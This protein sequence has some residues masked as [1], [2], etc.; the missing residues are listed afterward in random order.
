MAALVTGALAGVAIRAGAK[1]V[2]TLLRAKGGAAGGVAAEMVDK[3]AGELG[4]EAD[5]GA[6]VE[7]HRA[8]PDKVEAAIRDVE[9]AN[10][11]PIADALAA[12]ADIMATIGETMRA[13]AASTS[14]LQ[15]IWRPL[16][17]LELTLECPFWAWKLFTLFTPQPAGTIIPV[18]SASA[19]I[20]LYFTLRFAVV[21]V[22]TGGRSFE[23]AAGK[24]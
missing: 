11:K 20:V 9:A 19:L 10:M 23:K 5:P 2:G 15:R 16:H 4:V 8:A 17:A 21:G 6:I 14:L 3:I 18:V 7:A 22:Y 13:E 1:L 24:A 12:E